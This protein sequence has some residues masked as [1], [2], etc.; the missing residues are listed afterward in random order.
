MTTFMQLIRHLWFVVYTDLSL[1]T[2][3]LDVDQGSL[4]LEFDRFNPSVANINCSA[5]TLTNRR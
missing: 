4:S 5:F 1:V 3:R 2:W